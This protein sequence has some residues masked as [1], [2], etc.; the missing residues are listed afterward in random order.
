MPLPENAETFM[1]REVPKD[2]VLSGHAYLAAYLKGEPITHRTLK[3]VV[4][5][6]SRCGH[7]NRICLDCYDTW[8]DYVIIWSR[9]VAGRRMK[10]ELAKRGIEVQDGVAPTPP[11]TRPAPTN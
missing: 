2:S 1:N 8:Y 7:L 5:S 3:L 9:T 10:A 6:P 11:S 4:A